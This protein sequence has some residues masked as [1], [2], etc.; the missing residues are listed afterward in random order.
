MGSLVIKISKKKSGKMFKSSTPEELEMQF[1]FLKSDLQ[2][3]L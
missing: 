1:L 3:L 2:L